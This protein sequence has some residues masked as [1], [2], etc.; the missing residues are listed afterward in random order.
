MRKCAFCGTY[1]RARLRAAAPDSVE[2]IGNLRRP[3][4]NFVRAQK[5][6]FV[7]A[8]KPILWVDVRGAE[9]DF[10]APQEGPHFFANDIIPKDLQVWV[11]KRCHSK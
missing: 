4:P 3:T 8:A 7:N 1:L 6:D 9:V 10:C 2:S 5:L 11:G